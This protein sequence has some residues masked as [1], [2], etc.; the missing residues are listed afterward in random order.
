MSCY[1]DGGGTKLA[2]FGVF[3][4]RARACLTKTKASDDRAQLFDILALGKGKDVV[5]AEA[6]AVD[7][8]AISEAS[9]I[10]V[11]IQCPILWHSD[12]HF[13]AIPND[14]AT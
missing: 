11:K 3:P 7:G 13:I 2:R 14:C 1:Q 12:Q 8:E 10:I 6:A 9:K 5:F 4:Q